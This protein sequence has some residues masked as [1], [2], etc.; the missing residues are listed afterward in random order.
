MSTTRRI[1]LTSD[2]SIAEYTFSLALC[3]QSRGKRHGTASPSDTLTDNTPASA[4]HPPSSSTVIVGAVFICHRHPPS[5]SSSVPSPSVASSHPS[6]TIR[7][8]H[9]PSPL[10]SIPSSPLLFIPSSSVALVLRRPRPPLPSPFVAVIVP[11]VIV[12][13]VIVAA[14]I[15]AAVIVAAVIVTAV[16]VP[17]V[18]IRSLHLSP[19]SSTLP[20]TSVA[21]I[22]HCR[23]HWSLSPFALPLAPRAEIIVAALPSSS[24]SPSSVAVI[25]VITVVMVVHQRRPRRPHRS[26]SPSGL[27]QYREVESRRLPMK[28]QYLTLCQRSPLRQFRSATTATTALPVA[29][30]TIPNL[31]TSLWPTTSC[32][33][34]CVQSYPPLDSSSPS[35]VIASPGPR[36]AAMLHPLS[37]T[38]SPRSDVSSAVRTSASQ[39]E[40]SVEEVFRGSPHLQPL[41]VKLVIMKE[42]LEAKWRQDMEHQIRLFASENL[43]PNDF[44]RLEECLRDAMVPIIQTASRSV[45]TAFFEFALPDLESGYSFSAPILSQPIHGPAASNKKSTSVLEA[46]ASSLSSDRIKFSHSLHNDSTP[47]PPSNHKMA[48]PVLDFPISNRIAYEDSLSDSDITVTRHSVTADSLLV[49]DSTIG[50]DSLFSVGPAQPNFHSHSFPES[51][52]S[53]FS[54]GPA[55]PNVHSH[56]FPAPSDSVHPFAA[57]HIAA[58]ARL[59]NVP[60]DRAVQEDHAI[61]PVPLSVE[62]ILPPRPPKFRLFATKEN[63]FPFQRAKTTLGPVKTSQSSPDPVEYPRLPFDESQVRDRTMNMSADWDASQVEPIGPIVLL[64]ETLQWG[65]P[66][67][68][69]STSQSPEPS[70][71]QI[72]L[73]RPTTE[74][75]TVKVR[76]EID[77]VSEGN[78]HSSN[79]ISESVVPVHGHIF[80]RPHEMPLDEP[81]MDW[82]NSSTD[83]F[84]SA[85]A[86][87]TPRFRL[88]NQ[89]PL[90]IKDSSLAPVDLSDVSTATSK[91]PPAVKISTTKP[92]EAQVAPTLTVPDNTSRSKTAI[93]RERREAQ[94]DALLAFYDNADQF[95]LLLHRIERGEPGM[96]RRLSAEFDKLKELADETIVIVESLLPSKN[97]KPW[98]LYTARDV[99]QPLK[100]FAKRFKHLSIPIEDEVVSEEI[101]SWEVVLQAVNKEI[102]RLQ[103]RKNWGG[104]A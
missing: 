39:S 58:Q 43:V 93:S 5:A 8:P 66:A 90:G 9:Y 2:P 65:S 104:Q 4:K 67:I 76:D 27:V 88:T 40:L 81:S 98:L 86:L 70:I 78:P 62:R 95:Y 42:R 23:Q 25:I 46:D 94:G 38:S 7:H 16:I 3:A 12:A 22:L 15:V 64:D 91:S 45:D 47:S 61:P 79:K 69:P 35:L 11:A 48:S 102:E 99:Y 19:S 28:L 13:A 83:T 87:Q 56:S 24:S 29:V 6:L 31:A 89:M 60:H 92:S 63:P 26:V 10:P 77:M 44:T 101:V 51:D 37:S 100:A 14:V 72:S 96:G 103:T 21:L 30:A 97:G 55:Q 17:A 74:R 54:V 84:Q 80:R 68:S 34:R 20:S 52:D 1:H 73:S 50:D 18:I 41:Y 57:P 49:A 85:S 71:G 59:S 82:S 33:P 36:V 53:L 32:P 75:I